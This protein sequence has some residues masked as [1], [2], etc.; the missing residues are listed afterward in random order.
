MVTRLIAGA[1]YR[2]QRNLGSVALEWCWLAD[3]RFQLYLHGG[4]KLW[5]YAAG[6]LILQEAG[7][8][9]RMSITAQ[10]GPLG[11]LTLSPRLVAAAVNKELLAAW[12]EWL[13][14]IP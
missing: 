3:G 10:Y 2:S 4:Q 12:D 14:R 1:P 13:Q 9:S 11:G 7:G 5:D 8:F 6:W